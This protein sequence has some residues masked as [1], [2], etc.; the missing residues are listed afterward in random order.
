MMSAVASIARQILAA[1]HGSGRKGQC[2][3]DGKRSLDEFLPAWISV[4]SS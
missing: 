3:D 2:L 1:A 4:A